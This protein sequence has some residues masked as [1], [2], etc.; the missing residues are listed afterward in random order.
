MLQLNPS[1]TGLF[2][3]GAD[4]YLT[5]TAWKVV[6][7][8]VHLDYM[9]MGTMVIGTSS[10]DDF[11]R[12]C[13]NSEAVDLMEITIEKIGRLRDM[14]FP[15]IRL[16]TLSRL[17]GLNEWDQF[18]WIRRCPNMEDLEWECLEGDNE[19]LEEFSQCVAAGGWPKLERLRLH[20]DAEDETIATILG[21]L[22]KATRL[23]FEGSCFGVCGFKALER[24]L[25]KIV[26]LDLSNCCELTSLM[27]RDI[28]CSS[29]LLEH[30]DVDIVFAD[31]IVQG[32]PW[33]CLSLTSLLIQVG[34]R[35]GGGGGGGEG[36]GGG[37]EEEED[38]HPLIFDRLSQLS[39]LEYLTIN[40][41]GRVTES[42]KP[43]N[44]VEGLD[45][46]LK[47]GLGVLSRLK[48]VREVNFRGN[49]QYMEM[50]EVDW[51]LKHWKRLEFVSGLEPADPDVE[52]K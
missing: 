37:D 39:K 48:R 33:V 51:M 43:E 42:M 2:L 25:C 29:P 34:F 17:E 24:H 45:F 32:K 36:E 4:E 11:W 30:L 35:G 22:P 41:I 49:G 10:V 18:H 52:A 47:R 40:D 5:G 8:L 12:A 15:K 13:A 3:D 19:L 9:R 44:I 50:E 23:G 16:L 1:I 26:S 38:L 14:T 6:S 46:R 20:G 28:L 21:G 27:V 31:D 7:E